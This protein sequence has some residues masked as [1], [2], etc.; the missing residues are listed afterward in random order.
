MHWVDS[1]CMPLNSIKRFIH[2]FF[3]SFIKI[4]CVDMNI[5]TITYCYSW[6]IH[7][8]HH[9][10]ILKH[11]WNITDII[12]TKFF[13]NIIRNSNYP[14]LHNST[15]IKYTIP[16]NISWNLGLGYISCWQRMAQHV[17]S[18]RIFSRS[19][20]LRLL[21]QRNQFNADLWV[22]NFLHNWIHSKSINVYLLL[23]LFLSK[24]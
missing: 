9:N 1:D 5:K 18:W 14:S 10:V 23:P 24:L 17:T 8:V 22:W 15:K 13:V 19:S 7:Y 4:L 20:S 6:Y 2:R 3:S 21:H 12:R 11:E 16:V